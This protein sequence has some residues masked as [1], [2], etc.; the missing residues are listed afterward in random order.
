MLY[1]HVMLLICEGETLTCTVF[2]E[3]WR[4]REEVMIHPII[5][6]KYILDLLVLGANF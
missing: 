2:H 6:T 5:R 1:L 3:M 4:K